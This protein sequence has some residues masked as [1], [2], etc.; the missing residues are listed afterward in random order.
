MF[1]HHFVAA[2]KWF[3]RRLLRPECA[4]GRLARVPGRVPKRR[5]EGFARLRRKTG[6]CYTAG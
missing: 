5:A 2:A 4:P 3:R 6:L 1:R